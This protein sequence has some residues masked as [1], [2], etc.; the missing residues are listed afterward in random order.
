LGFAGF[1]FSLDFFHSNLRLGWTLTMVNLYM[2]Q[3]KLNHIILFGMV[4]FRACE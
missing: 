4:T 2:F 3:L 1:S